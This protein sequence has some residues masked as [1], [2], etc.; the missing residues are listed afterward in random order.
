MR[1]PGPEMDPSV[2]QQADTVGQ[3]DGGAI[4]EAPTPGEGAGGPGA[5]IAALRIEQYQGYTRGHRE[6][7]PEAVQH[8]GQDE[9]GRPARQ[10]EDPP[11]EPWLGPLQTP[12]SPLNSDSLKGVSRRQ[13]RSMVCC[14]IRSSK[15]RGKRPIWKRLSHEGRCRRNL[16]A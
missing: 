9:F 16:A 4:R 13:T 2:G 12:S 15:R 5:D 8:L 3:A 7:T 1:T 14:G 11:S 10:K 6:T